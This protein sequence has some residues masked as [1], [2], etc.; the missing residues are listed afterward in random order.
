MVFFYHDLPRHSVSERSPLRSA[1]CE[2][3]EREDDHEPSVVRALETIERHRGS[4]TPCSEHPDD[5]Q[6]DACAADQSKA[7][8][9]S[10]RAGRGVD[11]N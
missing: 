5:G 9:T 11:A 6:D 3:D 4:A 8:I 1:E 7:Q 2:S 10:D